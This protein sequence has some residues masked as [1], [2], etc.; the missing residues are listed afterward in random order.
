[1]HVHH[2]DVLALRKDVDTDDLVE[3]AR[4]KAVELERVATADAQDRPPGRLLLRDAVDQRHCTDPGIRLTLGQRSPELGREIIAVLGSPALREFAQNQPV[5]RLRQPAHSGSK[6]RT[7]TQARETHAAIVRG[8]GQT[9][10]SSSIAPVSQTKLELP[11][12]ELVAES[13]DDEAHLQPDRRTVVI[14]PAK[15]WP[16]LDLRELWHYRELAL[17]LVWRDVVV[18]YKQTFLGVTWAVLV[19]ALTTTVYVVVFGKF[20]KFPHGNTAYPALTA[21][22]VIPMQ[23]FAS[24]LTSSSNSLVSNLA[25]VTKV[26]FPRILLPLAAVVVPLFDLLIGFG[27]LLVVMAVYGT[28]PDSAAIFLAPAFLG[29]AITTALGIGFLLSTFTARWRDVPYMIPVFLQILPLVSG[30]MYA[31]DQIPRKWQWLFSV[32]PMAG[33]IAGWRWAL[34]GEATPDWGQMTV[35]VS[36]AVLIFLLGLAVFRSFEP[37]FADT[38]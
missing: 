15:R 31:L 10:A 23:Y 35:S 11:T 26:Y 8:A 16:H 18:R 21:A 32:N 33:V 34:L 22:G 37:R 17:R 1:M 3:P 7:E 13:R 9:G 14:R 29:L 38:I 4:P 5:P 24:A 12:E 36:V 2:E 28:W 19:P 27:V 30:V 20:A 6:P 25:L